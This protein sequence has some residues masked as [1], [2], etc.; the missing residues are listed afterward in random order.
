M[1]ARVHTW[2]PHTPHS[3]AYKDGYCIPAAFRLSPDELEWIKSRQA[4]L[5]R[6]HATEHPEYA[7]YIPHLLPLDPAFAGVVR[8]NPALVAMVQQVVGKDVCLWNQ[9]FF[10]KPPLTGRKVPFHQDGE[11]WPIRPLATCTV[12]IAIDHS[13]VDNGCLHVVPGSHRAHRL[14]EHE[15]KDDTSLALSLEIKGGA[16]DHTRAVPIELEPGQVSLHDVY[17]IHGSEANTSSSP[18]RGMTCRFMPTTSVYDRHI[19]ITPLLSSL[20]LYHAAGRDV[21]GKNTFVGSVSS[22][23]H[24][25]L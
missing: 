7:D 17:L 18:R 8:R 23:S 13:R 16:Y 22:E 10:A 3:H 21:S 2:H 6:K 19:A 20:P 25:K 15:H 14:F 24:S 12:W 1:R 5:V 11:Y 9:S 4:K